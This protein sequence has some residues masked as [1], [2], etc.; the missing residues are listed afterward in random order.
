MPGCNA[1]NENQ[2]ILRG[3]ALMATYE[4]MAEMI[5]L[6][7]YRQGSDANVDA[8][9]RYHPELENFLS[10]D[11]DERT[12]MAEDYQALAELLAAGPD[13]DVAGS[14]LIGNEAAA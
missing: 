8:A 10:Q 4:N 13:A 6:G 2:M 12:T 9:I 1:P 7:A 14:M 5:S 3:K 11:K